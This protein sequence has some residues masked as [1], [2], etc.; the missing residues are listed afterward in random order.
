MHNKNSSKRYTKRTMGGYFMLSACS[1]FVGAIYNFSPQLTE[2]FLKFWIPI[3]FAVCISFFF[4]GIFF[5]IRNSIREIYKSS[6]ATL[7]K[8]LFIYRKKYKKLKQEKVNVNNENITLKDIKDSGLPPAQIVALTTWDEKRKKLLVYG[9]LHIVAIA[10]SLLIFYDKLSY[11]QSFFFFTYSGLFLISSW[12]YIYL[13]YT[14]RFKSFFRLSYAV[15]YPTVLTIAVNFYYGISLSSFFPSDNAN[16]S[17]IVGPIIIFGIPID[18]PVLIFGA[19][20]FAISISEIVSYR[21][22]SEDQVS[23]NSFVIISLI[24]LI[25]SIICFGLQSKNMPPSSLPLPFS[26]LLFSI[27]IA[28]YLGIFEG[29]DALR[30]MNLDKEN[31]IFAKHYRW[32]NFLQICYPLAFFFIVALVDSNIFTFG[33]VVLFAIV[34]LLSIIVWKRGGEKEDYSSTH[35]GIW[36]LTFGVITVAIIF[37]NKILFM[38]DFWGLKCP[39]RGLNTE[40]ISV[41]LIIFLLGTINSIFIFLDIDNKDNFKDS[42]LLAFP[43][44]QSTDYNDFTMFC[45][46]GYI[47]DFTN[48]VYLV[49]LLVVHILIFSTGLLHVNSKMESVAAILL[50]LMV[51]ACVFFSFKSKFLSINQ[52]DLKP[53]E[54]PEKKIHND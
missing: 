16:H 28:L 4:Y 29:W 48:Y 8:A 12:F 35:W 54:K 2:S 50:I 7:D 52:N 5:S 45:R 41:E 21:C 32:W 19:F 43:L 27:A 37:L 23:S 42:I 18:G 51:I 30:D 44:G 34:S 14:L 1:F 25:I 6:D 13:F 10:V 24:A 47:F 39:P 26:N 38:N 31:Y 53:D 11:S 36:K 33:L 40:G 49:Y 9:L 20:F 17:P 46:G 22:N 15:F 3:L